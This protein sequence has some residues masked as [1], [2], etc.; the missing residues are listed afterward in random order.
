MNNVRFGILIGAS[1]S[2]INGMCLRAKK[3]EENNF[4]SLWIADHP[5]SFT[6]LCPENWSVL[7]TLAATTSKLK[8][9][10]GEKITPYFKETFKEV[11][12]AKEDFNNG[13]FRR[14]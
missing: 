6:G 7:A 4:N 12:P 1:S 2:S 5:L 10:Y 8:Q 3:A 11:L 9:L 13:Y 14:F